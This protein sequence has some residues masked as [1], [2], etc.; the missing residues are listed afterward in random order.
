MSVHVPEDGSHRI[1]DG[2]NREV[3]EGGGGQFLG[4]TLRGD[5]CRPRA[6]GAE[7]SNP[8]KFHVVSH[9]GRTSETVPRTEFWSSGL[10]YLVKLATHLANRSCQ[11]INTRDAPPSILVGWR[12][13]HDSF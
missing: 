9:G 4:V 8:L 10:C 6:V 7:S 11:E 13:V 12:K 3:L 1:H 2:H 5:A